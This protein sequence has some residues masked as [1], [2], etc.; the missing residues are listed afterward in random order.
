[1][2]EGFISVGA[3]KDDKDGY[4]VA[5][6][7]NNNVDIAAPGVSIESAWKGGGTKKLSGTS[8][9]TPHVAGV[10]ALW[11]QFLLEEAG[12]VDSEVL[13]ARLL[14]SGTMRYL[15]RSISAIDVG[16]GIVQAP[17]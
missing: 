9:A 15:Q 17:L 16:T 1:M 11:A 5:P 10:A 8:M 6:F 13:K 3:L 4:S 2:S 14:A 7:S 12:V